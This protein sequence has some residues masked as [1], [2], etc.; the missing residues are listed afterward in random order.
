MIAVLA[1]ERRDGLRARRVDAGGDE[2]AGRPANRG[3]GPLGAADVVVGDDH[4]ARRSRAGPRSARPRCRRHRRRRRGS[5]SDGLRC[6]VLGEAA[7]SPTPSAGVVA[8]RGGARRVSAGASFQS[9]GPGEAVVELRRRRRDV[10]SQVRPRDVR[11]A[12]DDGHGQRDAVAG[13]EGD[14]GAARQGPV[15]D[16]DQRRGQR[17]AAGRAVA[18]EARAVPRDV[19]VVMPRVPRDLADRARRRT[20]LG[21][22]EPSL[23]GLRSQVW[24]DQ[25]RAVV[26][27]SGGP[28]PWI[29]GLDRHRRPARRRR[30]LDTMEETGVHGGGWAGDPRTDWTRDG[31][32]GEDGDERH[33]RDDLEASHV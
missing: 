16:A 10:R 9:I 15:G 5:A 24:L 6:Q 8:R 11:A 12:V 26:Q 25:G 18:V 7:V 13:P 32:H 22:V 31:D 33:A 28:G 29:L 14:E 23:E 30:D 27:A 17:L 20:G 1:T 19:A 4:R 3:D 2:A 21:S